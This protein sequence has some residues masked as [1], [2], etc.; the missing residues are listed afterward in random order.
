MSRTGIATYSGNPATSPLDEVRFL[1]GDTGP[2]FDL[3]NAEI[4]YQFYIVYGFPF[5]PGTPPAQGNFL[6][7][8]YCADAIAALYRKMV[9]KTVGDLSISYS[10]MAKNFNDL[11]VR[12]RSRATLAGVPTYFGGLS[13]QQKNA[14]DRNR[15]LVTVAVK[16]D[17]M[18]N[19]LP[20]TQSA[21][22]TDSTG[23]EG[24][25]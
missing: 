7:A 9:D 17:G 18:D 15:D 3:N 14:N 5:P 19:T 10:Q 13:R 12:L 21:S 16:I 25:L 2:V 6:P 23:G 8:A 20:L 1:V 4:N 11:A 22:G 24:S